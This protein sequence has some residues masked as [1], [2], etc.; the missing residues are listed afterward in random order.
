MTRYEIQR[1]HTRRHCPGER[2]E[3][4]EFFS[5]EG[6]EGPFCRRHRAPRRH[7]DLRSFQAIHRG[8]RRPDRRRH[9]V[10]LLRDSGALVHPPHVR[11]PLR[12]FVG[13]LDL[14]IHRY[15]VHHLHSACVDRTISFSR[16]QSSEHTDRHHGPR[17]YHLVLQSV[18]RTS[19]HAI[20]GSPHGQ[21]FRDYSSLLPDR[22]P[23]R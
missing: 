4:T 15:R 2:P 18:R 3:R 22:Q 16:R 5:L 17:L 13:D 23:G 21:L 8:D 9:R 11:V 19:D 10:E 20:R 14:L 1:R 6:R 12:V 7:A